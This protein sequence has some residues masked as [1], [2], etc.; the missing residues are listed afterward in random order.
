MILFYPV[1]AL[2][3]LPCLM[4]V[5]SPAIELRERERER[6]REYIL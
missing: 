6:E 1:N 3:E 5:M 4:S 2:P